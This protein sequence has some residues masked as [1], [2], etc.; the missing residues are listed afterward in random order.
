M[1]VFS[2]VAA[3]TG[4]SLFRASVSKPSALMGFVKPRYIGSARGAS[5]QSDIRNELIEA[6][7]TEIEAE[8]NLENDNLGGANQPSI[9]GFNISTNQAEVRLTKSMGNEK[10]LVVFNVNHSVDVEEDDAE[11]DS[12]PMPMAMP[13]FSIEITSGNQRLCFNMALVEAGEEGQF[14]FR[15]EEFYIAPA[16]KDGKEEVPDQVYASSGR[17]IDPDLHDILFVKYLQERGIDERFCQQLVEFATH[18]EHSE[19]VGLLTKI[20]DFVAQ[21]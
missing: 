4:R 1:S 7:E 3:I 21:K 6:L 9:P 15:V 16:A 11:T 10:I 5:T 17:Y 18:Y 19:Y 14:D 2:R 12:V 8:R 13:P 20:K